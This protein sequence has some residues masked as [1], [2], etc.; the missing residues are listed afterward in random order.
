MKILRWLLIWSSYFCVLPV[1]LIFV[2][3]MIIYGCVIQPR[4]N[5]IET[6]AAIFEGFKEGHRVNAYFIKTGKK[7]YLEIEES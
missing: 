3:G 2:L 5:P 6:L 7:G 1:L 4:L